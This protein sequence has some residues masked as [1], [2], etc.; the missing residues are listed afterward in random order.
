[1]SPATA[2]VTTR[3]RFTIAL[4]KRRG[5]ALRESS[6][7]KQPTVTVSVV[8]VSGMLHPEPVQVQ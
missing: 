6:R 8:P 5:A 2:H 7:F 1:M 3:L 4:V